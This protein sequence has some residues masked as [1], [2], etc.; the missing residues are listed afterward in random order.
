VW[1]AIKDP[2]LGKTSLT[3]VFWVYGVLGSILVSALGLAVDPGNTLAMRMYVAFGLL[4]STYVTVA[5]YQCARNCRSKA[6]AWFVR[7]SAVITLLLLPLLAYWEITG[8]LDLAV[9]TLSI[10]Q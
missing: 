10:E 3:R 9:R 6:L 2:L 1:T 5:T 8:A 7:V 4:F